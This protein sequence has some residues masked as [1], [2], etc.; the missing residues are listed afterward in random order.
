MSPSTSLPLPP[1]TGLLTALAFLVAHC[2]ADTPLRADERLEGI[3]CRSVHLGY[4]YPEGTAFLNEITVKASSPGT[5]FCVCGFDAGYFGIQEL[6]NGKKLIIFSVWD[7]GKQDDPSSVAEEQRVKLVEQGEGVRVGRFGGE[8]T[9]GQSFFDHDW[10][11]G[12]TYRFLVTSRAAADRTEYTASFY[13]NESRTWKRL[14]TFSTLNGGKALRGYYSFIED[15]LR[16]RTSAT[17]AREA[18]FG[19]GWIRT[20]EGEWVALTRAQFTA[21]ANPVLNISAYVDGDRFG[22]AT[23]GGTKLAGTQLKDFLSRAPSGVPLPA[24]R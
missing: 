18:H 12:E 19:N 21:D 22:L 15:F 23:G 1:R 11:V 14:V 9:G 3:A 17:I 4:R 24:A 6:A 20:K 2:A 8:G 16:N 7:P 5:Y 10:K 13:L